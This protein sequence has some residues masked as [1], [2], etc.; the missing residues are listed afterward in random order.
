MDRENRI[1]EDMDSHP[2]PEASSLRPCFMQLRRIF[3]IID[4]RQSD[5]DLLQRVLQCSALAVTRDRILN[6]DFMVIPV[7][8]SMM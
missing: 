3:M 5:S 6:K 1:Q 4:R 2:V 7:I 8:R